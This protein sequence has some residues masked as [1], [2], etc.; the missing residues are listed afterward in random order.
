MD[1]KYDVAIFSDGSDRRKSVGR[2]HAKNQVSTFN[3]SKK[4]EIAVRTQEKRGIIVIT[5]AMASGKS[6]VAQLLAEKFNKGV[7]LRGDTFRRMIVSGRE[8]MLQD[9]EGEAIKQLR[10]RHQIT[11][12]AADAYF[13]AGFNVVIQD[14]IIGSM[15]QETIDFIRNRPLYVIVLTPSQE[16]IACREAARPKKGYGLWTIAELDRRL[17]EET[18]KIGMWLN[19]SDQTAEETVEQI[20]QEA[21]KEAVV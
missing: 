18:P 9:S 10:L 5:G 21:W 11:A 20:W 7:H 2:I 19:S 8:E 4:G 15:L 13:E 3:R 14:V 17:R 12:A 6:T 16:I 1:P